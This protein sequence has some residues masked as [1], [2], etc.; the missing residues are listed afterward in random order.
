LVLRSDQ[1]FKSAAHFY[2]YFSPL[3]FLR[4]LLFFGCSGSA[5]PFGPAKKN[6]TPGVF[7][8]SS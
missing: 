5:G 7:G 3:G 1:S 2:H 8:F 6:L 4:G